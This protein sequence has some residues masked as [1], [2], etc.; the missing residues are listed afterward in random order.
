MTGPSKGPL[1]DRASATQPA[2]ATVGH[3]GGSIAKAVAITG[4]DLASSKRTHDEASSN[5]HMG[6]LSPSSC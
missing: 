4:S 5:D 1:F 6:S 2:R 3:C